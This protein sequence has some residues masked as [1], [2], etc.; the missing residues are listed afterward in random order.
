MKNA[1]FIILIAVLVGNLAAILLLVWLFRRHP[2]P[3]TS[4]EMISIQL[5][6]ENLQNGIV[7]REWSKDGGNVATNIARS[8]CRVAQS[9]PSGARWYMYFAVDPSFKRT[10]LMDLLVTIEYFDH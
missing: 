7:L 3:A 10:E 9:Q 8:E 5:G 4:P 1:K 2:A 6:P